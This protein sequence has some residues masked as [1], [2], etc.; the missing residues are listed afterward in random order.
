VWAWTTVDIHT[1]WD[2]KQQQKKEDKI[3]N[4][5]EFDAKK[6]INIIVTASLFPK[7]RSIITGSK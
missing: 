2:K 7:K 3:K 4:L 1:Q 6:V 5:S